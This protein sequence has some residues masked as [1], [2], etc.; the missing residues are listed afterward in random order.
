MS[1]TEQKKTVC[2]DL[3][4]CPFLFIFML[5]YSFS[6]IF[7]E[8][9]FSKNQILLLS[10]LNMIKFLFLFIFYFSATAF[11]ELQ[12]HNA[13]E[14]QEEIVDLLNKN[15][16][17]NVIEQDKLVQNLLSKLDDESR[18]K[19]ELWIAELQELEREK[20][21]KLK[22]SSLNKYNFKYSVI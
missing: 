14:I 6:S 3:F 11:A 21:G 22:V 9:N 4:D 17:L 16:N 15:K 13:N 19:Y 7:I 18:R 12:S 1:K 8:E 5:F 20:A 10:P 2:P